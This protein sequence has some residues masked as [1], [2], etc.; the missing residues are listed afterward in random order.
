MT[1]QQ[2]TPRGCDVSPATNY[3]KILVALD[4]DDRAATIFASALSLSRAHGSQLLAFH[5]LSYLP[6]SHNLLAVGAYGAYAPE[7][8]FMLDP[9]ARAAIDEVADWLRA[10]RQQAEDYAVPY[11]FEQRV[12]T[13]GQEICVAAQR[14][15]ADLVVVGRRGRSGLGETIL[16]SVSNYVMHHAPCN[17]LV[18]QGHK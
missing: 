3:R 17:V 2:T 15:H 9:V 12:G 18:V 10:W 8:S 14:W 16:G 13:A 11:A 1:A 5:C 6:S 7:V 4:R